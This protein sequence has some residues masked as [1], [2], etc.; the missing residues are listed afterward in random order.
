MDG[1]KV[2]CRSRPAGNSSFL[3]DT[4][5]A[6][7][8]PGQP[9][10]ALPQD[11]C[12]VLGADARPG[13]GKRQD[14]RPYRLR[15]GA[16]Q[17][18]MLF[19][20]PS[21]TG[22]N[23]KTRWCAKDEFTLTSATGNRHILGNA[24]LRFSPKPRL[25]NGPPSSGRRCSAHRRRACQ[26]TQAQGGAQTGAGRRKALMVVIRRKREGLGGQR[27]VHFPVRPL[28]VFG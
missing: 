9:G 3:S 27:M 20:S 25:V 8:G 1:I 16:E 23:A 17:I 21:R 28:A 10:S 4:H 11:T 14:R 18:E 19:R 15:T 7:T 22:S 26:L 6:V 12:L 24:W 2:P 5:P 13:S